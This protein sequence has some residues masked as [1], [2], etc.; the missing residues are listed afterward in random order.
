[1]SAAGVV[2]VTLVERALPPQTDINTALR[3]LLE[4]VETARVQATQQLKSRGRTSDDRFLV[5]GPFLKRVDDIVARANGVRLTLDKN[6]RAGTIVDFRELLT[7]FLKQGF[8]PLGYA[9]ALHKFRRRRAPEK[10]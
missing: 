1:N 6:S 9:S 4:A 7:P 5:L 2:A 8:L 3:Q 10:K